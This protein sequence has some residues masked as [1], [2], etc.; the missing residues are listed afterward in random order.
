MPKRRTRPRTSSPTA[1]RLLVDARVR[2]LLDDLTVPHRAKDAYNR[3]LSFGR[4][5]LPHVEDGLFSDNVTIRRAC[6]RAI[7]RLA[8]NDSFD[9]MV[10]LT[11]DDDARVRFHA[12]HALACDNCKAADV[13]ALP[14][15][16]LLPVALRL[17]RDD[18]A[19]SVRSVAVEVAGRWVHDDPQVCDAI[20]AAA[21]D[22]PSSKVRKKAATYAPG[23]VIYERTKRVVKTR[24]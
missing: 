11:E 5:A 23:G 15:E 2:A 8:G 3:I 22:D 16:S 17:M 14:K 18:P 12:L 9:I 20:I 7:D 1:D 21:S 10:L 6:A 13:C 4:D 24:A 19:E